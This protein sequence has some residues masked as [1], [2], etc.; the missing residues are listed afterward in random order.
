MTSKSKL[1][2]CIPLLHFTVKTD[3]WMN[4]LT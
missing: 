1:L 3:E 4:T 2:I